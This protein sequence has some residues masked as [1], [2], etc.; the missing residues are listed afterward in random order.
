VEDRSPSVDYIVATMNNSLDD[1]KTHAKF[2]S[3]HLYEQQKMMKKMMT[4][5]CQTCKTS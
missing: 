3:S 1:E 2:F 5:S 4:Q